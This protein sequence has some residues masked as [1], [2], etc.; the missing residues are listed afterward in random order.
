MSMMPNTRGVLYEYANPA[1][2]LA[3]KLRLRS[4]TPEDTVRMLSAA[5]NATR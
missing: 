2:V 3:Q 4:M 1:A 5:P